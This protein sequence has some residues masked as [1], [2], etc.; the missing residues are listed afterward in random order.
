MRRMQHRPVRFTAMQAFWA[1]GDLSFGPWRLTDDGES[2]WA[3]RPAGRNPLF[4]NDDGALE[5][6][7][8]LLDG[9][10]GFEGTLFEERSWAFWRFE[11]SLSASDAFERVRH[12]RTVE[13]KEPQP[14]S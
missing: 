5:A 6:Y 14:L 12:V 13:S 2:D 9:G 3:W 8:D 11:Q 10:Y 7:L 4:L 1:K